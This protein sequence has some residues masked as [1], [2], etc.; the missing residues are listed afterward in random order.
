MF[1]GLFQ[2]VA[3]RSAGFAIVS[4]ATIAPALQVLYVSMF[5]VSSTVSARP[6]GG[7][8]PAPRV[9]LCDPKAY[10]LLQVATYP[11]AVAI[12]STNVYEE[13]SLGIFDEEDDEDEVEAKFATSAKTKQPRT[14]SSYI[15]YHA[16]KQLAFDMWCECGVEAGSF[17]GG[18]KS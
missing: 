6:F 15:S 17:N 12:R 14:T 1:L 8:E 10:S 11:I 4:L 9:L 16:R 5:Q 3:V 2:A 13:K 18:A 7:C